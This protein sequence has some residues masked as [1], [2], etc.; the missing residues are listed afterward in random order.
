[1]QEDKKKKCT[2]DG[3]RKS[4]ILVFEKSRENLR[5]TEE[6][7][8]WMPRVGRRPSV[9]W[10]AKHC[11]LR[12]WNGIIQFPSQ[13]RG[14]SCYCNSYLYMSAIVET[15]GRLFLAIV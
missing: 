2:A 15:A 12:S 4:L 11:R 8:T 13:S 10:S 14:R 9:N 1:M 3:M 7:T 5:L 6:E